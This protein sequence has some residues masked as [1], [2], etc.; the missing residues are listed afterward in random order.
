MM[1]A[2]KRIYDGC[3][4]TMEMWNREVFNS[5]LE[6][7]FETHFPFSHIEELY[8]DYDHFPF[9]SGMDAESELMLQ[10]FDIFS[11]IN[12]VDINERLRKYYENL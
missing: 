10:M 12:N 3:V 4:D 5:E 1:D 6:L 9:Y 2:M 7:D 8:G 11:E